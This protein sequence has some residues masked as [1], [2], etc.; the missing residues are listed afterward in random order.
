M[1]IICNTT[2]DLGQFQYHSDKKLLSS[3]IS[4]LQHCIGGRVFS[5]VWDDSADVG[6]NVHSKVTGTK[7]TFVVTRREER[8]QGDDRE[9]VAWH[10]SPVVGNH[11]R[12]KD[13]CN[14]VVYND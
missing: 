1:A 2:F 10:L 8:G 12:D 9:L 3:E 5:Q 7:V 13:P 6:F 4:E 14:V 11:I